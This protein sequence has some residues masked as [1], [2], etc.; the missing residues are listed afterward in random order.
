MLNHLVRTTVK[1]VVLPKQR[2]HGFRRRSNV[3][4]CT[5]G[6]LTSFPSTAVAASLPSS[7]SRDS[8]LIEAFRRDF[9]RVRFFG[10]TM[11]PNK[12]TYPKARR[13]ETAVDVY[14]GVE[15]KDPYKWLEDPESEE[16]KAYVDAQN[17]I[18][19]PFI[20]ACPKRQ[21][22][23]DRLKQLWDYPKYSCPAKKGSKYYFFMNTGL[24]NQSVFYVQDSL[25][26]EPRVFLDPNTFSTDGT[27]AISS[28]EFSEDG[29]IYAYAL[30]A[31]G[32][33]W[34]TIHFINT[35]TG[36]KYPEVLEK[37]K[38]SSI[39]WTHDNVGVF[40]ACYPEQ[41]EK[42]DGSET[43]VNKNQKLCY[44]KVGTP[45][46]EDVVVVDFPEHPLWRIDAK[47]TDCGR[48]LV[49]MPQ[50]ECRDNL[51]FFAK[52]NTAEGI[53][54]KLPLT[55]VVGNLEADYEYVTNVGTKAVFRT[56]KNAPNF[57]LIATDFE[58]Y[59]ENSWSELIAEHSRN[60]LDWATAVDKDKLVVCYIEDVK[61]VLGVHSLETGK[62]IRQLPLDVGTVVG[63]SGDLKYSE[64]FYQFTSFL[65]P[66][67]I[68]TLDLKENEE[69]PKV[70][71][72]I[73]VNDFDASLYKTTQ[74]FYSSKDGTKIPMFIVHKKDLV[75][76]GSSPALLYGYGGFNV[77]IQPTFSVT[78]LVFLQHLN[79]VLAIPNIRGGGEYG[80]KWH[81]GGR[82]TNK[83][84]VF[85]DFQCAAEYLIDNR[86]TSPKKLIIQ[87]GSNGGLLVGACINQRPDLFGAAI[88]QVGV[89]DMLKF[90]KFTVGYAWTSDYGSSDDS[91]HFKNLLKYSPLHNVKPPKDGGQYPATLLLTADHDDRVV[92]LHS[93]KLIATL[94][95]EIGSLPQQTN[96]IL[97]RIDVKA[98]HGRGKPTSKVIDESTDILSFVV[99]T[100][101]LEF[102]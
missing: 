40:Y 38:Y 91:E 43:F 41:L 44:H 47:V 8:P 3:A 101:N 60:V 50:Q 1:K 32:S 66:G 82:F 64:I 31:S 88:A 11:S 10:T 68:Y 52:L 53:K 97:I 95:H 72:E 23:H 48:W 21:A 9:S 12:F 93:L 70:F 18:T 24:Q 62:L 67:I 87:G 13:D 76:D 78:R 77:S 25:D 96:P 58:N 15:I 45:Q 35:K 89:M 100:L 36:E 102:K 92:P 2:L 16:T 27:V 75:L 63:F 46:S 17:A 20:Q 59:Q 22:I 49:V 54:G 85:D 65:T 73:K 83:Q 55:E 99:Q 4:F 26:G 28:G 29:G 56:N 57:K 81:N 79:G 80:E 34:N 90:H 37:V 33:D 6:I 74:I 51:V 94:Q 69:K 7:R 19:V 61:N 86:Y 98:G 71:R 42:A 84:N 14:H 5:G 30:S 39:T